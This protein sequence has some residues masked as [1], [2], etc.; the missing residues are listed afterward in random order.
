MILTVILSLILAISTPIFSNSPLSSDEFLKKTITITKISQ[1]PVIDGKFND[2]SWKQIHSNHQ[3]IQNKPFY[4]NKATEQT[5]FK[6]A[7]DKENLYLAIF[8]ESKNSP[9]VYAN[10]LRDSNLYQGD[11]I[12]L[13]ID[14][15]QK[16]QQGYVFG[17]NPNGALYDATLNQDTLNTNWN[18]DWEVKTIVNK[19]S[20]QA[21]FKIPFQKPL[22]KKART[23]S[24]Q[25]RNEETEF[26]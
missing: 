22:K 26:I 2:T 5:W 4:N 9:I 6:I 11:S 24:I 8:L 3:F 23:N 1:A 14:P 12:A 17:T 13:V 25:A 16:Q 7:C 18:A 15:L 20:W 10:S 21:E 19:T